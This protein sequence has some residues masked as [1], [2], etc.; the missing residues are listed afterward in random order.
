MNNAS[1]ATVCLLLLSVATVLAQDGDNMELY[2]E[3]TVIGGRATLDK[4]GKLISV[5]LQSTFRTDKA[6][7]FRLF[8]AKSITELHLA[9]AIVTDDVIPSLAKCTQ[10][11]V[12]GFHYTAITER[13]L[14]KLTA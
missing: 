10:L 4:S 1:G 7:L 5:N 6:L 13:G 8:E 11:T 2:R 12:L 9:K 14:E 3:I